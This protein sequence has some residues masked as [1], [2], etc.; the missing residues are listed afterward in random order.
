M[1]SGTA[2]EADTFPKLLLRNARERAARVAFRHKDLGIWQSWNWAEVAEHVRSFAKGLQDLGL[3]RGEKVAIIGYNRPRLYWSMCAAQWLGAVPV[4]VYADS[5]AEEMA[6]VLDHAEAV[7]A[8]VQDQEQVD[9]ILSIAERLPHLRHMLYDEPR[10]LRD[11]DHSKLHAIEA[12]MQAG[13]KA[14]KDPQ[15]AAAL[16]SEMEAG[17][18]SDLG[19]ILYTSGTTGRPKG[20]MLSHYNILIAAEIGCSFDG[21]NESDEVIAYLPIAWVGDHVFSY[22]QAMLAGFCVNCPESPET[23]I[24]DRREVGTT[25]AF[26][27]PRVFET[28]LTITMVRMEDAGALKR[29]MFHYFLGVAKRYGE[30]ILN[31]ESVPL[32][33]RLLYRL[34]DILVYGPLRN[35][36]GLTNIK[37]GYTAGEAIGP[38]LFRFYRSIGVNL[39]QLY[40]QTEAGVYI[41]MQPNGEIKADTVGKPA[42]MVEIRIDD[43]GEV[44]YRSPSIFGGYYKDP[45]KTAE[46]MTAD[47]YVRSGDA[48]FFDEGGHLKIIDRAKDVGKLNNG[49]LFPPKYIENK[50]KFYPN[51]KEVVAFGQG[52]DYA[53]VALNIDLTAVGNWAER[54]NVVYAS[55]QE[56]AGHDLVYDMI[57]KHVDEVN[58]SLASEPM[59]GGAQ[60]RRFLIL[61]KELDADDGELTRTQKVRRGFIAERYA[62]LVTALYDGSEAA[63][64]STEVTFEDGRKGVISARVKVRDAKTYPVTAEGAPATAKAA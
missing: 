35:R 49:D 19:I 53:T 8:V 37:V 28:M 44:L 36:F 21:L 39:K 5:V 61:H 45:D 26:A 56:L 27:P 47:G 31:G 29:K 33:G 20:V 4:P 9:K 46:T 60:I 50:L 34:G 64:I 40:G 41:T 63:D 43:N 30:Q 38:E 48:G 51:I 7:F 13:A 55:Y 42:P 59:M 14:L 17:K 57:A 54:H 3:K 18:G 62:P 11:Y 10:G 24:D 25:Y 6:Y 22:A 32:K 16:Q 12:V 2:V 1:A 23:V 15:Q 52:R 58:R